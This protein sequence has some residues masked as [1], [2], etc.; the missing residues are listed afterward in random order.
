MKIITQKRKTLF[1]RTVTLQHETLHNVKRARYFVKVLGGQRCASIES[2]DRHSIQYKIVV[3]Y[4]FGNKKWQQ[5]SVTF[6]NKRYLQERNNNISFYQWSFSGRLKWELQIHLQGF[7]FDLKFYFLPTFH[8]IRTLK[9]VH[10]YYISPS[11][12]DACKENVGPLRFPP[13][14]S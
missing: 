11:V 14:I 8:L 13:P 5:L 4:S 12:N 1:R 7:A 3:V 9:R 10:F 6:H 2:H